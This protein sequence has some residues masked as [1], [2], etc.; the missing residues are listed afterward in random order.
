MFGMND[1]G[2]WLYGGAGTAG[3]LEQ[4]KRMM[5]AHVAAMQSLTKEL[6]AMPTQRDHL[7]ADPIRSDDEAGNGQCDGGG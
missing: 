7:H 6:K 4:R 1:V 5:D 3:V 2:R